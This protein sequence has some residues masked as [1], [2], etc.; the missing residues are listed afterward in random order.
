MKFKTSGFSSAARS[1]GRS[2]D[3]RYSDYQGIRK[4]V[5]NETSSRSY[6]NSSGSYLQKKMDSLDSKR[7]KLDGFKKQVE[8]FCDE[9]K[10]VDKGVASRVK[11][12]AKDVYKTLGIKTGFVAA[13]TSFFKD[14]GRAILDGLSDIWT[15]I[16]N[17]AKYVWEVVKDFYEKHKDVFHVIFAAVAIIAAA[18]A[19]IV[20][21]P[22]AIFTLIGVGL[23]MG[24]ASQ[25]ISDIISGKLSTW[26]SYVGSS[27]GGGVAGAIQF[28]CPGNTALSGAINSAVSSLVTMTLENISGKAKH[29]AWEITFDSLLSGAISGVIGG[30]F[31]KVAG[32]KFVTGMKDKAY[33]VFRDKLDIPFY[34]GIKKLF[35]PSHQFVRHGY[36]SGS[37]NPIADG[38]R[39]LTNLI[40]GR[41]ENLGQKSVVKIVYGKMVEVGR[42][43]IEGKVKDWVVNGITTNLMDRIINPYMVNPLK[44]N[45]R[46]RPIFTPIRIPDMTQVNNL[47]KVLK[48]I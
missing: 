42:K 35:D 45:P 43:K 37:G 9:A 17:K 22:G 18:V 44:D 26:E 7:D 28:L 32:S 8:G 38:K 16:K 36:F 39:L 3:T 13:V 47:H 46:F 25:A 10:R 31:D 34:N 23:L 2:F 41:I 21:L 48:A 4:K 6:L 24:L 30:I 14:A 15:T 33:K 1:L 20:F 40:K 29:S 5:L 12:D 19:C 27:I 11:N